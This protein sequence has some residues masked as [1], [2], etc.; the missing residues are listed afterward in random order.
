MKRT[1]LNSVAALLAVTFGTVGTALAHGGGGGGGHGGGGHSFGGGSSGPARSISSNMVR[2]ANFNAPVH[3]NVSPLKVATPANGANV[4]PLKVGSTNG[5]GSIK[6]S[7]PITST[8]PGDNLKVGTGLQN[9]GNGKLKLP[10]GSIGPG[11]AGKGPVA[12]GGGAGVGGQPGGG[13]GGSGGGNS[14]NCHKGGFPIVIGCLPCTGFYG[15]YYPPVYTQPVYVQPAVVQV[16][17]PVTVNETAADSLAA[18]TAADTTT[19]VAATTTEAPA[20]AGNKLPQVPV[21]STLTLQSKDLGHANGQVLLVMDKMTMGMQI[22]EW[23]NDYATATLPLIGVTGRTE[24]EIVLVK[25]D[26]HAASSVKVE[27]VPAQQQAAATT[28]SVASVR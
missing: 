19:A 24:S 11:G 3:N 25:A 6:P 5:A 27:L 23:S 28:D 7:G 13:S 26:G 14:G 21:G 1:W 20:E 10:P 2:P 22:N 17:T 18:N 8:H 4:S 15:G 9:A 12:G 16:T